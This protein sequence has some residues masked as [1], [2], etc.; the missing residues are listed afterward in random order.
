MAVGQLVVSER[1]QPLHQH[2]E[3][4]A[5]QVE[6]VGA[7]VDAQQIGRGLAGIAEKGARAV[8]RE[9]DR[10]LGIAA[11]DEVSDDPRLPVGAEQVVELGL[12]QVLVAVDL[13]RRIAELLGIELLDRGGVV[14]GVAHRLGV[15]VIAV[16]DDHELARPRL[17]GGG[18]GAFRND[19]VQ[20]RLVR[21]GRNG[22]GLGITARARRAAHEIGGVDHRLELPP[23]DQ[24]RLGLDRD[25]QIEDRLVRLQQVEIHRH[26]RA[27]PALGPGLER[28]Q[29]RAVEPGGQLALL[30]LEIGGGERVGRPLAQHAL[31]VEPE[32]RTEGQRLRLDQLRR[33]RGERQ[34]V[35][36]VEFHQVVAARHVVDHMQRRQVHVHADGAVAAVGTVGATGKDRDPDMRHIGRRPQRLHR[37]GKGRG[38]E[39]VHQPFDRAAPLLGPRQHRRHDRSVLG[40][41][42]VDREARG[43]DRVLEMLVEPAPVRFRQVRIARR[44]AEIGQVIGPGRVGVDA[45]RGQDARDPAVHRAAGAFGEI[46]AFGE[47]GLR[48]ST[49]RRQDEATDQEQCGTEP[50]HH[51]AQ[52]IA[53][54]GSRRGKMCSG[55]HDFS[56]LSQ[57][58]YTGALVMQ[59]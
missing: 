45:V 28:R 33:D 10:K 49:I 30:E 2:V 53:L 48:K 42:H 1:R 8:A 50:Q 4:I 56:G 16:G 13:G 12:G 40:R 25:G 32:A 59:K 58:G 6:P 21:R 38:V 11:L 27:R 9:I 47:P 26:D 24:P 57:A 34:P 44:Q 54:P 14:L 37:D 5:G 29:P 23:G 20:T 19:C 15:A 55:K 52:A 41:V 31:A 43:A 18:G 36:A 7:A 22:I 17:L 39:P 35:G 3:R 46:R 51:K